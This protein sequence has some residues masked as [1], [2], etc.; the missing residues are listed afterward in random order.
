[1]R[2]ERPLARAAVYLRRRPGRPRK[3]PRPS[4]VEPAVCGRGEGVPSPGSVAAPAPGAAIREA[5][6]CAVAVVS[7]PPRL[8]GLADAGKYLG[9]S[10]WLIRDLIAAGTLRPVT[11]PLPPDRRG[12]RQDGAVRKVLLDREDLDALV[13]ASKARKDFARG[14]GT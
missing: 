2:A 14:G 10:P 13:S 9:L 4:S 1:M 7:T 12:R 5:C 6:G 3:T 11:I 8:L